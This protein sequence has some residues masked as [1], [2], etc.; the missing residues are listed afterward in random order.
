MPLLEHLI[1]NTEKALKEYKV[2]SIS[3]VGG[4]AANKA[5][6][7]ALTELASEY[8]KKIVIPAFEFCGDN[9]A[10]IAYRGSK[11]FNAGIESGLNYSPFPGLAADH[12]E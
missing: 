2:N 11:L 6:R 3:L 12:F 9:A 4:V 8:H 1:K 5:L 10:M 7:S